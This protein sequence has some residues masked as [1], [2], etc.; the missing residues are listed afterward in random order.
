MDSV[1]LYIVLCPKGEQIVYRFHERVKQACLL[2][3]RALSSRL[4]PLDWLRQQMFWASLWG[5][6]SDMDSAQEQQCWEEDSCP[7]MSVKEQLGCVEESCFCC[8]RHMHSGQENKLQMQSRLGAN[9]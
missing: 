4:P 6:Y 3:L 7:N 2:M 8:L 1:I 5:E 9:Q